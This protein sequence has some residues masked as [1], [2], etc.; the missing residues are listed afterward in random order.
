MRL[1]RLLKTSTFQLALVYMAL[2]ASSVLLLMAF[3]YWATAGYMAR[4]TDATIQADIAGLAEQYSRR[5]LEGLVEIIEERIQRDPDGASVYLF[6]ARD[7]RPLAGNLSAWPDVPTV[8]DGWL[9]FEF[10]ESGDD[11]RLFKAR[12]RPFTLDGG[13][14][15]LVGRDIRELKQTQSMI[16]RALSWGLAITLGLALAGGVLMTR[17]MARRI[18]QINQTSRDIMGGN[19]SR[20]IPVTGSAD[21]FDQLG[22]NLNA[23]LDEIERLMAGIRHVSDNVA[24]D[25]RTPLTRLR[26][27]LEEMRV[28]L[29]GDSPRLQN[30]DACIADADHLL[31][32]FSALLRIARIEAGGHR[33]QRVLVNLESLLNDAAELYEAL[34]EERAI[35]LRTVVKGNPEVTGDRDL[36]FQAIVNLVDNAVKY[37]PSGGEI[38]L[39]AHSTGGGAV[40][41]CVSDSGPGIPEQE[42]DKVTQRFYRLEGSRTTPGSGLG[43]SLVAAVAQMHHARL[44]LEDNDPGLRV[45]LQFAPPSP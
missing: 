40:E 32:T 10:R 38:R 17:S 5:G 27:R 35:T 45:T 33:S 3:I 24:H 14:H 9:A 7:F 2:F 36:L 42:R 4:Q 11:D 34:G 41:L 16:I 15:L 43:L 1:L 22:E 21:D 20:R 44:V 30:I 39:D 28:E 31:E 37:T 19:L 29:D 8:D 25:L 23:M 12:A 18:D 6:A 13:L 26:T